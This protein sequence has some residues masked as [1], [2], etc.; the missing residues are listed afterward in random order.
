MAKRK[1]RSMKNFSRKLFIVILII[2]LLITSVVLFKSI[3][4]SANTWQKSNYNIRLIYSQSDENQSEKAKN[5]AIVFDPEAVSDA[6]AKEEGKLTADVSKGAD[7]YIYIA[8]VKSNISVSEDGYYVVNGEKTEVKEG[9]HNVRVTSTEKDGVSYWVIID[10]QQAIESN[11]EQRDQYHAEP[12]TVSEI[13]GKLAVAGQII[14]DVEYDEKY[15]DP[16]QYR[17]EVDNDTKTY[18]IVDVKTGEKIETDIVKQG[19]SFEFREGDGYGQ[20]IQIIGDSL[21]SA[22]NV[23]LN[24]FTALT[25]VLE[26][27][28]DYYTGDGAKNG[29][30]HFAN[31]YYV[32]NQ[33]DEAVKLQIR[34]KITGSTNNAE[35]ATRVM[36]SYFDKKTGS[37]VY[38]VY[39]VAN[40][41]G[42]AEYVAKTFDGKEYLKDINNFDKL[43]EYKQGQYMVSVDDKLT[44]NIDEAWKTQILNKVEAD[45]TYSYYECLDDQIFE[46]QAGDYISYTLS[47]WFEASDSDHNDSIKDGSI[48]FGVEY[49]LID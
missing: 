37:Y 47:V 4:D 22:N 20:A 5:I 42:E 10:G 35:K 38:K 11:V 44:S 43:V 19:T 2:T 8:G 49:V 13:D 41:D 45:E 34:V 32:A 18:V 28:Q 16:D 15:N 9:D 25:E 3:S 40:S 36:L 30:Q 23:L 17:V 7:D 6:A 29:D 26:S 1:R 48:T 12:P 39:A 27:S 31:K 24:K 14:E 21:L 46:I 33:N